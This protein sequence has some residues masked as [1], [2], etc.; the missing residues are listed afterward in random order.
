MALTPRLVVEVFEHINYQGRKVTVIDSVV[1][2][3]EV[4]LQDI[5]SSIKIYKGP[6]FRAAP[7][8]KAIFHEHVN[9]QGRRLILAP[10]YYPSIHEIPYNFGDVISSISFISA[11]NPILSEYGA[12]S[13]VI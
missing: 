11:A 9:H 6:G 5:I 4:G 7:N 2:T 3:G 13:F 10:G 1:N 8:Y 12:I